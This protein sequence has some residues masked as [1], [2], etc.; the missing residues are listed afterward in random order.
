MS[1]R[2]LAC[3]S[4]M[5]PT[6]SFL[7]LVEF[8]TPVPDSQLARIDAA[9]GQRADEGVVHDLE[10]EPRER[11]VVDRPARIGSPRSSSSMPLIARRC[12]RRRQ[13]VDDG[14]EQRLHALV[15]EGGAAQHRDERACDGTPCG[16]SAS[17]RRP[18]PAPCRRDRLPCTSS[19]TSTA[20][21]TMLG[22]YSSAFSFRS[23]GISSSS[24]FAPSASSSQTT[25]FMRTRSTT[26]LK[27]SS[28][29]IGSCISTGLRAE[30]VADHLSTQR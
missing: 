28:A 2:L 12:R 16:C 22:A 8:S 10:G 11:L 18:R 17:S 24:N 3:I 30:A 13:I 14:V 7:S 27:S 19:S 29:P 6:R 25:A 1:S 20:A 9:E 5:R 4:S 23:A 26:P 15:L 21:S